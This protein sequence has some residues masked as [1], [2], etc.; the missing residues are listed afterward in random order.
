M[1]FFNPPQNRPRPCRRR[2]R[3]ACR[4][5]EFH[6]INSINCNLDYD[7]FCTSRPKSSSARTHYHIGLLLGS[8]IIFFIR[9]RTVRTPNLT[10]P[11][12]K[13]TSGITGIRVATNIRVHFSL[14]V[15]R[16]GLKQLVRKICSKLVSYSSHLHPNIHPNLHICPA[17]R[18]LNDK[19]MLIFFDLL[20]FL[21]FLWFKLVV[22][23]FYRVFE[24]N[25]LICA[26]FP[27][28]YSDYHDLHVF[29]SK[30]VYV[31]RAFMVCSVSRCL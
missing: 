21:I 11:L 4:L 27:L 5:F 19:T 26:F 14:I 16:A 9:P 2:D 8:A 25:L 28:K 1:R 3:A 18:V 31:S 7:I 17:S 29:H 12:T 30:I 15:S 20:A 10:P 13:Y 22:L 23:Q 24:R 6:C